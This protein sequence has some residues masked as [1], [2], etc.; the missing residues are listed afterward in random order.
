[1]SRVRIRPAPLR[2]NG[3][4]L[5]AAQATALRAAARAEAAGRSA[6]ARQMRLRLEAQMGAAADAEWLAGALAETAALEQARGAVV[7]RSPGRVRISGRDGLHTLQAT[8]ALDP[9]Q[10]AAGLRYRERFEA[11][12][13]RL[14][15]AL[16]IRA[17]GSGAPQFVE[18]IAAR[19]AQARRDLDCM[20]HAVAARYAREG[21]PALAA[22]ALLVL[23]EV[24]GLGRAV[25]ELSGSGRRRTALTARLAETLTELTEFRY[26]ALPAGARAVAR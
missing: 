7:E 3:R 12:H 25:R 4:T 26:R 19:Q 8:G 17:G 24:A 16:A 11:A 13:P 14:A 10:V 5:T 22:D 18:R 2:V 1:M 15:S 6:Q 21:R 20:E 9:S 23:R